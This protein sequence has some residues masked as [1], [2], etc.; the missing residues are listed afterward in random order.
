VS[1]EA[2]NVWSIMADAVLSRT[3]QERNNNQQIILLTLASVCYAAYLVELPS[4]YE[5][6]HYFVRH[7][8][9]QVDAQCHCSV[10]LGHKIAQLL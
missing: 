9:S 10:H 3:C 5:A 1:T 8:C 7:I 2:S 6:G 4:L